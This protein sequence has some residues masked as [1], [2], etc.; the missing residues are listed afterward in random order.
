MRRNGF[1]THIGHGFRRGH[2]DVRSN[3]FGTHFGHCFRRGR[4]DMRRNSFGTHF[5][6]GRLRLHRFERSG[7]F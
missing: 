7:R 6:R 1:G 2:G 5:G 3:S 4:T